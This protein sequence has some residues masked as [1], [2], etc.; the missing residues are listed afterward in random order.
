MIKKSILITS[1]LVTS[2]FS[3]QDGVEF[4]KKGHPPELEAPMPSPSKK[5][6][7]SDKD[8]SDL[9]DII[10]EITKA[11]QASAIKSKDGKILDSNG[12]ELKYSDELSELPKNIFYF[13]M[14]NIESYYSKTEDGHLFEIKRNDVFGNW[15]L[16][17]LNKRFVEFRNKFFNK[18]KRIYL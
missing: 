15:N 4:D 10:S 1:M 9:K 7:K 12:L 17:I 11:N 13:S 3:A 18:T 6:N 8:T 16:L 5:I 2:L 14:D